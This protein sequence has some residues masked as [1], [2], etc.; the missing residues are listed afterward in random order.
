[1]CALRLPNTRLACVSVSMVFFILFNAVLSFRWEV[2]VEGIDT[3]SGRIVSV[4]FG[5]FK[6]GKF[7]YFL[8]R[9][10]LYF[11]PI[12]RFCPPPLTS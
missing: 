4:F 8:R 1:M 7:R 6:F 9:G 5:N 11:A 2:G 10:F 12:D 3:D